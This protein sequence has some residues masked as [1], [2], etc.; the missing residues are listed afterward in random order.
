MS[1]RAMITVFFILTLLGIITGIA[2]GI[3]SKEGG[4]VAISIFVG[5]PVA[6]ICV[7]INDDLERKK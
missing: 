6:A 2:Y 1:T 4:P 7:A 5:F 3:Y